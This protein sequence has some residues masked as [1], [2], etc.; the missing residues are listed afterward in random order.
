MHAQI[1]TRSLLTKPFRR[2]CPYH[3]NMLKLSVPAQ[4]RVWNPYLWRCEKATRDSRLSRPSRIIPWLRG[5]GL[6]SPQSQKFYCSMSCQVEDPHNFV[7]YKHFTTFPLHSYSLMR[8]PCNI[9]CIY[10]VDFIPENTCHK[11]TSSCMHPPSPCNNVTWDWTT[12]EGYIK[13]TTIVSSLRLIPP[14]PAPPTIPLPYY[15]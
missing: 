5:M 15:T 11:L 8:F 2:T 6:G 10:L 1:S 4:E 14:P 12:P 13:A 9:Y 3:E 7:F